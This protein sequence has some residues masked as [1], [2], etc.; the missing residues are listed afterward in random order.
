MR[1]GQSI[2][3]VSVCF[4]WKHFQ[5]LSLSQ[6]CCVVRCFCDNNNFPLEKK[7]PVCLAILTMSSRLGLWHLEVFLPSAVNS[8]LESHPAGLHTLG[9]VQWCHLEKQCGTAAAPRWNHSGSSCRRFTA[10]PS[11]GPKQEMSFRTHSGEKWIWEWT[12][13]MVPLPPGIT[14]WASWFWPS[15]E[16]G[17]LLTFR[18]EK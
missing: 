18:R 1:Q 11:T 2:H 17:R 13:W 15:L 5:P 3:A 12:A 4:A 16:E 7:S 10:L 9:G 6:M 8:H 14:W